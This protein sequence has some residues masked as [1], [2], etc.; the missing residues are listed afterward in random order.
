MVDENIDDIQN[1]V[2]DTKAY[3][4]AISSMPFVQH[5][6]ELRKRIFYILGGFL[7][8]ACASYP[9]ASEIY[10]ILTRPLALAMGDQTSRLIFTDLP[11]VFITYIKL[12]LYAGFIISFPWIAIQIWLFIAPGLYSRERYF[13]LTILIA[14][15]ILF[16]GGVIFVYEMILPLAWKFFLSFQEQGGF[17]SLPIELEAKVS[18][19]F[20]ITMKILFAFG[21]AF[22][23]PLLMVLLNKVGIVSRQTFAKGRRF[24]IVIIFAI[25]A[26]ITPPDII[27]Q[28]ALALPLLALYELSL[29]FMKKD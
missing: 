18:D 10:S 12:S 6:T 28:I 5:L 2:T 11:E 20:S 17:T 22:Q 8:C 15:P 7:L 29:L 23:L 16:F 4:D 1:P 27:S 21:L 26:L 3:D 13:F 9:F 14:T 19:Y 25:A 24:A